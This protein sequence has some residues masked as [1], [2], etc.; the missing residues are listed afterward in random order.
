MSDPNPAEMP[1]PAE[2][3]G[4]STP[5]KLAITLGVIAI[6]GGLVWNVYG[7][8]IWEEFKV[9]RTELAKSEDSAPV[10]YLGLN[11]RRTYNDRPLAFLN[12]RDG[13]KL[14]FAA[15]LEGGEVATYDITEADPALDVDCLSGG[16]GR[17]SIPGIDFPVIEGPDGPRGST[18]RDRQVVLGVEQGGE[19]RAYPVDLLEKIE[20]VNDTL[21]GIPIAVVFDRA[22]GVALIYNRTVGDGVITFGTTGYSCKNLPLLYD[23]KTKSLWL[24]RG[25][26]LACLSGSH[27]G[28][29]LKPIVT[30]VSAPW[31]D[32]RGGHG[33]TT[34]VVG[35]DRARDIPAE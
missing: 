17:D 23:R 18:L 29:A 33:T 11:F 31:S 24:P 15:K 35:N 1:T 20:V 19:A 5:M 28:E 30:P 16:F 27:K 14:L 4:L 7:Y 22:R 12:E 9:W 8:K 25:D 3:R 2:R 21:G 10:G 32:W 26:D 6:S 13:K 34:V